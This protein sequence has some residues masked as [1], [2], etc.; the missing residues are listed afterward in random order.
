MDHFL[1]ELNLCDLMS[2]QLPAQPPTMFQRG[3]NKID[4]IV[5]TMG[6]HLATIRAYILPFGPDSP[7]SDHAIC[8]IDF[9]LDILSGIRPESLYDP[10]HPAA[11]QL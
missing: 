6:V 1:D 9:S 8:G 3:R 2:N 7:K 10:T 5:G 11:R 4:H